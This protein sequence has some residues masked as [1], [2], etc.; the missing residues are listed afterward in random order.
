MEVL[1]VYTFTGR[2]E[3]LEVIKGSTVAAA[4]GLAMWQHVQINRTVPFE[5]ET[6]VK[7]KLIPQLERNS[8]NP[9]WEAENFRL[10]PPAGL[11]L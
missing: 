9:L 2:Q 11:S 5:F 3:S 1:L 7:V 4:H 8:L 10:C 6:P